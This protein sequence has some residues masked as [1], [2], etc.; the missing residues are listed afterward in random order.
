MDHSKLTAE[1]GWQPVRE[2][3]E[4]LRET[5]QWYRDSGSWLEVLRTGEY[6]DYFEHQYAA[7]LKAARTLPEKQPM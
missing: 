7:R 6:M 2:F 5:V 3:G 4:G 1:L